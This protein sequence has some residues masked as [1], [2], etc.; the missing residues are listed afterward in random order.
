MTEDKSLPAWIVEGAEVVT[1]TQS[2]YHVVVRARATITK[3]MKRDIVLS[4]GQRF[5]RGRIMNDLPYRRGESDWSAATY[6]APDDHPAAIAAR[7][8]AERQNIQVRVG[9]AFAH[10]DKDRESLDRLRE[11][12][13]AVMDC[14]TLL[15]K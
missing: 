1:F 5:N 11:L 15:A 13:Y 2:R 6:L 3:I 4:D 14:E 12:K 10:W 7:D 8:A 9:S